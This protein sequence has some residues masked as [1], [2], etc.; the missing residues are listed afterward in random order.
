M[1]RF[2]NRPDV[3][4]WVAFAVAATVLLIH[5]S[6][7]YGL[8]VAPGPTGDEPSY[9]NIGWNLSHGQ[10]YAEGSLDEDFLKPYS[11][12]ARQP[13][14][15]ATS[16]AQLVAYRPP[17]FPFLLSGL[18]RLFGR[19]FWAVRTMNVIAMAATA[20]LLV[21]YLAKTQKLTTAAIGFVLFLIVDTRTRL[22]GRAILTE[23]T[24]TLL[25]SIVT[26]LFIK[27]T[28]RKGYAWP[29]ML[30][31][32][33]GILILDRSMFVL[34]IPM[35]TLAV[36]LLPPHSKSSD[37]PMHRQRLLQ[38]VF[39]LIALTAVLLP[40][41]IR[42]ITVLDRFMPMGTQG[43]MQLSAGF[44]DQAVVRQGVWNRE[45]EDAVG[46][47]IDTAGLTRLETEVA[48]ADESRRRAFAWIRNH[49]IRAIVLGGHKCWQEYRPRSTTEW[50]IAC[51]AV[52]GAV[53]SIHQRDTQHLLLLH[54]INATT[55]AATWSVEGRFVVPLLL[56]I[57]IL[58]AQG[59]ANLLTPVTRRL[60]P[61]G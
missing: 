32:V 58:A 59:A 13:L 52:L 4:G 43:M 45:A 41:A 15:G 56:S 40:W 7:K 28:S 3:V 46:E 8:N 23:A 42:N 11:G 39:W 31:G 35:M 34:W 38:T 54:L 25:M 60:Q 50:L 44:S 27:M 10:G 55:I 17:L 2:F 14:P 18:N 61:T 33:F 1:Y 36:L 12:A 6:T 20:G 37:A 57:H 51:F 22:Y 29:T 16:E 9:D 19:Q 47:S 53:T 26:L 48:V 21:W 24:A 49:P 5:Y 30:G